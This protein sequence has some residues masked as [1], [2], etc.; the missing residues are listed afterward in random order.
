MKRVIL[1]FY[2]FILF[3]FV[4]YD[5]AHLLNSLILNFIID[6]DSLVFFFRLKMR[7]NMMIKIELFINKEK[8]Q[9][10]F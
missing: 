1:L 8:C 6:L 9:L 10:I 7:T 2:E 3:L 4:N 5:D